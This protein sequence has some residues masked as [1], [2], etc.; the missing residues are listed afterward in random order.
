MGFSG[1]ANGKESACQW[2]GCK[3]RR[4]DHWVGKTAWRRAWQPTPVF[5]PG[6]SHGQRSLAGYSPGAAKSQIRLKG[7][8]THMACVLHMQSTVCGLAFHLQL[9]PALTFKAE[10]SCFSLTTYEMKIWTISFTK[11]AISG[12]PEIQDSNKLRPSLNEKTEGLYW[13]LSAIGQTFCLWLSEI[14][15][16]SSRLALLEKAYSNATSTLLQNMS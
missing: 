16:K 8:D 13:L 5:L 2:R 9:L 12:S 15:R 11:M 3:T 1:G 6:E 4:F 14:T 7:L 10:N